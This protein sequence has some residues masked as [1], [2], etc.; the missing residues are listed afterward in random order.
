MAVSY[1]VNGASVV[2]TNTLAAQPVLSIRLIGGNSAR[3]SWPSSP[4][5]FKLE[6]TGSLAPTTWAV[7]TQP[8]ADDGTIQTLV[9]LVSSS[10]PM[11]YRLR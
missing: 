1:V 8:P 6:A 7:V 9:V 2:V 4:A 11:F 5:G 3:L 10:T